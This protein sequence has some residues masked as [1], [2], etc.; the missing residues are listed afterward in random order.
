MNTRRCNDYYSTNAI[1]INIIV[2]IIMIISI[3]DY[4]SKSI[5]FD[6]MRFVNEYCSYWLHYITK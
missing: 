5:S 6:T 3:I 2:I 4:L 1:I